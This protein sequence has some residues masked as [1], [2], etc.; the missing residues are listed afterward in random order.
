VKEKPVT[1]TKKTLPAEKFIWRQRVFAA[2]IF[3]M[4]FARSYSHAAESP[5]YGFGF[6]RF[7]LTLE[8]GWRSEAAGPFFYS[9]EDDSGTTWALPPFFSSADNPA[10]ENH[11]DDFLYPLLT[12]ERYGKESRWQVG[13]LLSFAGGQESN[14]TAAKRFTLYP[15]YFQQRSPNTND[16]YTALVPIYGHIR[17][18]LMINNVFFILFPVYS[19]TRKHDV[20]TDNY[21][22]PIIHV[23]RGEGLHGWQVWPF[24][25]SEHKD[26]TTQTN[27]FG[28]AVTIPG[29][30]K[31]FILWPVHLREHT[32]IG[33]ENPENFAADF[34]FY[35]ATRSPQRNS[36]SVMWPIFTWI[37][38]REKKYHEWQG[39][40]PL[41]IFARGE[42]KT[43]SRIFPLF[44]RS[45]NA[46]RETDLY[47]WP[48]Y[49]FHRLQT[50]ALD[51]QHTQILF[52]LYADKTEKNTQT[53][54]EKRR[55]DMWPFFTWH[56]EFNGNERLQV[57]APVEPAVPDNRGIE[58]NWS[59]LWSL[60]RAEDNAKTGAASRS[61]LWN[62]YR[63][64]TAPAHKKISLLFGL[65]QYQR[66]GQAC[67]TRWFYFTVSQTKPVAQ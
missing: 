58:R 65:F 42:G 11:E 53:G 43:T 44:S 39:P 3:F 19:E 64:D 28:D 5:G 51:Q 55:L 25:G 2:A 66:D 12:Y 48:L 49:Q 38:E 34:P 21:F 60:W 45:H 10:I 6:D 47:L 14:D 41:V 1:I 46:E 32:G 59:P 9:Q 13:Q 15:F 36:T 16:N 7:R 30:D 61:L 26:I 18:R 4:A 33:T 17:N 57:F 20:V 56:H 31:I 24:A 52:Y 35:A 27:G 22:Y 29:H 8:N 23:R 37:D 62:L 50:G 54:A 63:R 67:R 40:W